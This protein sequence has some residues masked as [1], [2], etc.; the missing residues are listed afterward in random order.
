M[1]YLWSWCNPGCWMHWTKE[2][3][4]PGMEN[5]FSTTKPPVRTLAMIGPRTG[6]NRHNSISYSMLPSDPCLWKSLGSCGLDVVLIKNIQHTCTHKPWDGGQRTGN[7]LRGR[8]YGVGKG[9]PACNGNIFK[10]CRLE[11]SE[12]QGKLRRRSRNEAWHRN[13]QK[14]YKHW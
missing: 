5:M 3:P 6:N 1:T 10:T 12:T 7:P 9:T 14:R 8:Q 2:R 13:A 4:I 11:Q